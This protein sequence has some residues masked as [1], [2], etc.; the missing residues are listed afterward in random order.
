MKQILEWLLSNRWA[1]EL[2]ANHIGVQAIL[3]RKGW[4]MPVPQPIAGGP[5]PPP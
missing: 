1:Q 3:I 5:P 2:A 4:K